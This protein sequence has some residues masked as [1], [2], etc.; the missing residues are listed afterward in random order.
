MDMKFLAAGA[1]A[2]AL[3][4]AGSASAAVTISAVAG[5][6][7]VLPTLI[8]DFNSDAL[9]HGNITDLA[10]G[11]TFTQDL[12]AYTRDGGLGLDSGVSAPPPADNNGN[13]DFTPTGAFYET[14]LG[15]GQATL[16]SLKGMKK[17]SFYMGSPDDWNHV[18]LTFIGGGSPTVL[19]GTDIWGGSP[20]GNG[21]Q[22]LGFTVTYTFDTAVNQIVFSSDRNAFEF[23]KLAALAVPEPATWGLM[24]LGFA[25]VGAALRSHRR[26]LTAA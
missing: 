6:T 18:T 7:V 22:S 14:V 13:G 3:A 11:F 8:T 5:D 25:G 24:I 23:D 2:I 12:M 1:A 10:A 4:T 26:V 20:P 16:T 19:N 15:G 17:F 9:D 21:D